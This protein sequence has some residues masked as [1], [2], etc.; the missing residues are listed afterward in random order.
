M[1]T[2][3]TELDEEVGV[4]SPLV[5]AQAIG[6]VFDPLA[7]SLDIIVRARIEGEPPPLRTGAERAWEC[8][9]ARWIGRATLRSELATLE[10]GV[11]APT[12]A[13]VDALD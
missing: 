7:R 2:L 13:I 6:L 3:R 8:A 11:V 5:D 12:L 1:D 10:G 9:D 4:A